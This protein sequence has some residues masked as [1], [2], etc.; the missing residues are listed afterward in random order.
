MMPA[1]KPAEDY[2]LAPAV[3]PLAQRQMA[4]FIALTKPRVVMMVVLTTLFG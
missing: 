4:D 1:L 3:L 2:G